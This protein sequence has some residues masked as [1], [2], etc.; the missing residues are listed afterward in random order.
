MP[1]ARILI[2]EDEGIL[3]LDVQQRLTSLGYPLP[4]IASTG[5]EAIRKAADGRPDLI[6]MDIMLPGEI[7]GVT[8][9]DRIHARF[10]IPVI[11]ITAYADEDTLRGGI[12]GY[13]RW[14]RH[15]TAYHPSPRRAGLGRRRGRSRCLFLLLPS[16]HRQSRPAEGGR[17]GEGN[18]P[19]SR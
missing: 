7:D 17:I 6:L 16:G 15:R 1:D 10:D 4:D 19:G 2:V 14:A 13:G 3:A 11:Y 12:R 18:L 8:A 5:A 9:T